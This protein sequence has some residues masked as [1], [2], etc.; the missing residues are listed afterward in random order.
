[1][2]AETVRH[3]VCFG[4]PVETPDGARWGTVAGVLVDPAERRV[5]Y[6]AV[7]RGPAWAGR[8]VPPVS[9]TWYAPLPDVEVRP[10]G[11][12]LREGA[13]PSKERPGGLLLWR[14]T[15]AVVPR[16]GRAPWGRLLGAA[17]RREDGGLLGLVV[18]RGRIRRERYLLTADLLGGLGSER[19]TLRAAPADLASTPVF[20]TDGELEEAV[21]AAVYG[22]GLPYEERAGVRLAVADGRVRLWGNCRTAPGRRRIEA[23]VRA[24]PGVLDVANEVID[25][26]ELEIAVAQALAREEAARDA[27]VV[28]R[29]RLGHVRLRGEAPNEEAARAAVRAA[30]GVPGVRSVTSEIQVLPERRPDRPQ[31]ERAAA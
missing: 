15:T 12:L 10:H 28:V 31:P 16:G 4:A 25:D 2:T 9:R 11:V 22:S 3:T 8:G 19:V 1:M 7:R 29:S 23:A 18:R 21:R 26:P 13:T 17:W 6:L 5:R 14:G 24:V 30:G 27:H 20:R